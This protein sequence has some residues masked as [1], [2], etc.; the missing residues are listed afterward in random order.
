MCAPWHGKGHD[1][2]GGWEHRTSVA[3]GGDRQAS[4]TVAAKLSVRLLLPYTGGPAKPQK[5]WIFSKPAWLNASTDGMEVHLARLILVAVLLTVF[6]VFNQLFRSVAACPVLGEPR[7][8]CMKTVIQEHLV[9]F[10]CTEF[11]QSLRRFGLIPAPLC[12]V[13]HHHHR[14]AH[15]HA[16]TTLGVQFHG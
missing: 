12:R 11:M 3:C 9:C 5:S 10:W 15:A 16:A 14:Q 8:P 4:R 13:L 7:K 6:G 2:Y 1:A